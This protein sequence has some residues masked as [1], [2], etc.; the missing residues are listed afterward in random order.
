ME[1]AVLIMSVYSAP[2]YESDFHIYTCLLVLS[3]KNRCEI[4]NKR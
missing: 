3:S 4:L 1:R 2:A